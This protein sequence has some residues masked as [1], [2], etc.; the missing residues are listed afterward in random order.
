MEKNYK[1]AISVGIIGGIVTTIP[2][3]IYFLFFFTSSVLW[4]I[5]MIFPFIMLIVSVFG[6]AG[7]G[8]LAVYYTK[9]SL[10]TMMDVIKVSGTA[11]AVSG[12]LYGVILACVS[13]IWQF[14]YT[15]TPNSY[16]GFSV[17]LSAIGIP[18]YIIFMAALNA[19]LAIIGGTA[20]AISKSPIKL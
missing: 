18:L 16:I 4:D 12:I 15:P 1:L 8:L 20:Y 5:K 19:F 3:I 2:T 10:H 17:A 13:I 6:T 11:G 14:I 7:I 9:P